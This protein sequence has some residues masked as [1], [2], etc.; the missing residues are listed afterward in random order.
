MFIPSSSHLFLHQLNKQRNITY[1]V[2]D[3]MSITV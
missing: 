1:I 3:M 2:S